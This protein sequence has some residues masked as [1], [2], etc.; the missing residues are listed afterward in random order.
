M[1]NAI[2]YVS[3]IQ[4]DTDGV[5]VS[6]LRNEGAY[7]PDELEFDVGLSENPETWEDDVADA[8][9]DVT[10]F[11]VLSFQFDARCFA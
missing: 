5:S 7:L 8:I 3:A 9:S 4:Y 11:C 6:F 1:K 10:G 2:V